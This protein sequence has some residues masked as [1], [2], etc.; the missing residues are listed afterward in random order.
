VDD[1]AST[2][3]LGHAQ[4]RI[5]SLA[6]IAASHLD[7]TTLNS[8]SLEIAGHLGETAR[9]RILSEI[10]RDAERARAASQTP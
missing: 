3:I 2:D 6:D 7:S 5:R 9:C 8:L 10:K 4:R 1:N